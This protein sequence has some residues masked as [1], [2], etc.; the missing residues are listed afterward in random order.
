MNKKKAISKESYI[1]VLIVFFFFWFLAHKIGSLGL[2]FKIIMATA[3]DLL[4]NTVFLIMAISVLAGALAALFSEFGVIHL[5][6]RLISPIIK[7]MYNLPGAASLGIITTYL[8]DNP[9]II[10]LARDSSFTQFFLPYQLPALTNLGTSFGMGLIL[11][12]YMV[13]LASD[14]SFVKAVLLGN[15]GAVVGSLVS[16][17]IMLHFTKKVYPPQEG[18]IAVTNA[19]YEFRQIREGNILQRIME[20]LLDGGKSGVEI[21]MSIVP[22]VLIICTIVMLL[23]FGPEGPNGQYLGVAYEGIAVLPK[24]GQLLEF[25]LRPLFGFT[26]PQAI[27]FPITSLGSVGAAMGL[28]E[29]LLKNGLIGA[30]DIAVFTAMGMTWSGYLST[31]I[32]MMDALGERKLTNKALLSHT[33]G[34]L[35][36]GI[37]ARFLMLLF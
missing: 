15:L 32:G 36:A 29:T 5:L 4:L 17:R 9:A 12:A 7:P 31:H 25:I 37:A 21:G 8:S 14:G 24:L 33:I 10:S 27:A 11:S 1:I 3:H 20:A 30:P 13:S 28:S 19:D 26:S 34:G 35:C 18:E 22:G 2:L 16:V 6:N 23:T